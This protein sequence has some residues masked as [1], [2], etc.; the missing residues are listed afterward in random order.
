MLCRNYSGQSVRHVAAQEKDNASERI[1][2]IL[3]AVGA[4]RCV[5]GTSNCT[6]GC[7]TLG[8]YNGQIP[9]VPPSAQV[10]RGLTVKKSIYIIFYI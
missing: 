8:T 7:S 6:D 4:P 2:Y 1:L 5:S 3:H 10:S 9:P